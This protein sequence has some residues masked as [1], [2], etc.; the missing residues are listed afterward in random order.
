MSDERQHE[1]TPDHMP[2]PDVTVPDGSASERV[3]R[4]ATARG[5]SETRGMLPGIAGISMFMIFMTILNVY[6]ALRGAF[7][8]G[9]GKY[10]ILTLSTLLAI[11]IFGLLRLR[12]WGWALV[13][14]GCLL[15]S[16]GDFSFYSRT[17]VTFFL[18]RGIFVLIFFLYLVR[19]ETRARLR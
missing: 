2:H 5:A 4:Q 18:V 9:V 3:T 10:G 8:V 15:V 16:T 14:A 17:H 11:G 1:P 6:A 19:P 7:G 12:K 13:T